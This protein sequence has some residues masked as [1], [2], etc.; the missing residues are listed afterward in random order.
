MHPRQRQILPARG[1]SQGA[2]LATA[3]IMLLIVLL[4]GVSASQVA[5]H[6]E[7]GSRN[8]RDRQIAFQAAEAALIDAEA[9]IEQSTGGGGR[10]LV[11]SSRSAEGFLPGCGRGLENRQLGL[12]LPTNAGMPPVWDAVNLQE[13]Q[14]SSAVSVPYGHFTGRSYPNGEGALPGRLPRYII[15]LLPYARPGASADSAGLSYLYRITAIGFGPRPSTRVVL[16]A[17]YRKTDD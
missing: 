7:K 3:L 12:C 2:A 16:Q 1:G 15:E 9:D 5:L 11:F 4:L 13:D 17:V 6:G 10:G 8:D 14:P